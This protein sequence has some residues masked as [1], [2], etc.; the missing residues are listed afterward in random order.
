MGIGLGAEYM[1][2]PDQQKVKVPRRPKMMK[3]QSSM[4]VSD[5][6]MFNINEVTKPGNL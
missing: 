4:T 2:G 3:T 5:C 6:M 1:A